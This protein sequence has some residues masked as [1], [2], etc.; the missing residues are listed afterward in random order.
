MEH[1]P[2]QAAQ[3]ADRRDRQERQDG[4]DRHARPD[5]HDTAPGTTAQPTPTPGTAPGTPAVPA[6]ACG[7]PPGAAPVPAQATEP[8]DTRDT[9]LG[10]TALLRLGGM[11]GAAWTAGAAEH[12]F[13]GAARHAD[14]TERLAAQARALAD[15]LGAEVVPHPSLASADRGAVLALRRRLHSGTAPGAPDCV[16]LERSA[17]VPADLAGQARALLRGAEAAKAALTRLRQEVTAEQQRVA[18]QAWRTA[19]SSPVM[20]AFLDSTAPALADDIERR[21]ADGQSWSGKQLRK[22]A[23]YLWRVVGRAAV[24][25]TPRGWAGQ[26]AALPVTDGPDD[27]CPPLLAPGTPLGALAAIAVENVHLLRAGSAL[28]DL[29]TADPA[30]LL[31]PTPLHFAEPS[32]PAPGD[33]PGQVRCYVVDPREP[34]RLRQI[35]LRR[36]RVL[37]SV[38]ALLADGPRTL[39]ELDRVLPPL[40]APPGRPAVAPAVLRGFLQH[41]HGLGVVQ[42]CRAPR[43][44]CSGWVPVE[45]VGATGALPPAPA[46]GG[47][48]AWFLDSYRRLGADAAVPAAAA[49]RVRRGLRIAARL[50]ALREADRPAE[51]PERQPW[52]AGLTEQARPISEI[53][54]DRLSADEPP[55][56]RRYTGW[57]PAHDPAGGY[58]RL[59]ARLDAA[60]RSGTA[61]VDVDDALLDELGAPPGGATLPPWPVDC[62][63]RPL[64]PAADGG[65]VAV[66]ETASSAG[67]LDARFADGLRTLHG[68]YGNSDAY[69]AFLAAVEE[70]AGVR[71]VDLLVPPLAERSANAVRRPVTT[72][73]WTGDPDPTPYY[74]SPGGHARY[75]PL[76]RISLRRAHG[77]IVAEADGRRIVPVYQ[78]TRSPAPPYD[79]LVRLLLAASHPA[80]SYLVRLDA[81]DA[82]L[83]D[84]ARLPRLTAGGDLVLAPATWRVDRGK[85]W[86]PGDDLLTKVRVLALLRRSAGLPRHAFVR[87]APGAKPVPVDLA[88]L[89]ALQLIERLCAREAGTALLVEEM[90]PAPEDLLLRDPLHGGASVAAQLLL[91]LPHDRCAGRLAEAAADAL[92]HG[93]RHDVPGPPARRPAGAANTR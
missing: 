41:L 92:V 89:T 85:L 11:P 24:K 71:F 15:R 86:E 5:S 76:D 2:A 29:R 45:T 67:V 9:L 7:T 81:L 28:A 18:E 58:A 46:G 21:L 17:A 80:A 72:R 68:G 49:A 65:P 50:A 83:P 73:W 20:R 39:G 34:G 52:F 14:T 23:A 16:L 10:G 43:Q 54:A 75:L 57:H 47:A 44:H 4:Q 91:R 38:L 25:T 3:P 13:E 61:C 82:A 51:P 27:G 78:A 48:D 56:V 84:R 59:L 66:L 32:A 1:T 77:R 40:S 37:E 90:L 69:R 30:T 12:L 42:I 70:R 55:P 31:A 26:I 8:A 62:L 79:T 60:A 36:T 93:G 88:S 22:R 64:P 33:P 35:V 74:G 87:T 6:R 19:C 53:L 63:L